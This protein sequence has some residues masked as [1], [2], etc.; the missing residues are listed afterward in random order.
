M[1]YNTGEIYQGSWSQDVISGYGKMKFSPGYSYQGWWSNGKIDNV[2]TIKT[3]KNICKIH[4]DSIIATV[5][6]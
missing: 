1:I 2:Y 3:L 4:S 6:I 5:Y